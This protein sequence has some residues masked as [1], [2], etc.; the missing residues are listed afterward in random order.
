MVCTGDIKKEYEILGIV[1][2]TIN[3]QSTLS[4]PNPF[5]CGGAV[6]TEVAVSASETYTRAEQALLQQAQIKGGDAVIYA[7]FDYRI[8]ISGSGNLTKQV[9]ELF[10]YGTAVKI[11]S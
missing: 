6:Q 8:A 11:S 2:T 4:Q 9:K 1:G 5:G 10:C 7:T 3:D